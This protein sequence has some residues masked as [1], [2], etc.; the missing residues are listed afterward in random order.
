MFTL[1]CDDSGTHNES[2]IAVAACYVSTVSQWDNFVSDWKDA[3]K[4]ENFGVFHMADFV[5]RYEQFKSPEWAN[6]EKRDRTLKR[7][8]SI[9]RIR[10]RMGFYSVV[11]KSAYDEE[12]PK[13]FKERLALG[14]NHYTFAV[15]A[16]LGKVKNW[17]QHYYGSQPIQFIFDRMTKGSGDINAVFE[18]AVREGKARALVHGIYEGGWLFEN[19]A[20]VLPLQAADILAWEALR[21]MQK[22]FLTNEEEPR[23]SYRA[24]QESP[25]MR[26]LY[27]REELRKLVAHLREKGAE[28]TAF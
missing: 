12:V 18:Q 23:K 11:E 21:Y 27:G 20:V 9:I 5:G 10:A 13:E 4:A 7:L 26:G 14:R 25:M 2:P 24:L 28:V 17:L 15:R 16:C 19:K 8:I 6:P 3:N 22:S 1:H